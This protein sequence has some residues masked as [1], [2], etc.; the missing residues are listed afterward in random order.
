VNTW[1]ALLRGVNVGGKNILPMK[2]LS[3]E[4]ESVGLSNVIT[5]IQSGNIVFQDNQRTREALTSLIGK[6]IKHKFDLEVA[7]FVISYK[8]LVSALKRNPF[9]K[10]M[11]EEDGKTLH[12]FFMD[13][14][15]SNLRIDRIEM[16]QQ[17]SERWELKGRIF[18][19]YTPNGFGK[20]KL[21]TQVE[22]ILGVPTTARNRNTVSRIL[23]L[24][25][26]G[27]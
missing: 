2:S 21:G 1:I 8:E 3:A 10:V 25:T 22:K 4:L 7:V 12:I 18:Y 5:Y 24:A 17:E 15:P 6:S 16:L 20:S 13:D 23:E 19:L 9:V 11:R 26:S 27:G 14:T